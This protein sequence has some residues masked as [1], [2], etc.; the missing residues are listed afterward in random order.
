MTPA[1][2]SLAGLDARV[3][4]HV[5][6]FTLDA[7]LALVP[8]ELVV[9]LGPNGAG[10]STLLRALAGLTPLA[11]GMVRLDGELLEAPDEAVR[12]AP[13]KR[14]VGV[15][16]QDYLLF[17]HLSVLDN[18]AFGPRSRGASRTSSRAAAGPWIEQL[19]LHELAGRRPGDLS[20]GQQQRVALARAMATGP[21]LLLLD[22]P[23]AA[24]DAE[25]RAAVRGRAR[26]WLAALG[27]PTL[28]VTHDPLDALLL[29]D[30][31]VVLQDGRVVQDAAPQHV[32]ARPATP[33]VASLMGL[34]LWEGAGRGAAVQLADGTRLVVAAHDLVGPHLVAARP[35]AL[36][37][38]ISRP[39]FSARNAWPGV[40]DSLDLLGDR[41]RV[42]VTG[43]LPALVDVTPAAVADLRLSPGT[44]V[45]VSAKATEL[46]VYPTAAS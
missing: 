23:F 19:D 24:L 25:T 21:R 14:P 1:S 36:G 22:E 27:A 17:P 41:V 38:H 4:A 32:A 45:W 20:G 46:E 39:E 13:E 33:W 18:V 28:L 37:L 43:S 5:G 7:E 12:L 3:V 34:N 42:S 31:I 16:F 30:R 10:K 2:T 15:V 44:A 35:S 40:V 8:G 11:A 26:G 29:A 9:V 6:E